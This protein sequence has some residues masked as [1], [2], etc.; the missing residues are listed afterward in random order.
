MIYILICFGSAHK[1]AY[2]DRYRVKDKARSMYPAYDGIESRYGPTKVHLQ[3]WDG[4]GPPRSSI[5]GP[6]VPSPHVRCGPHAA[7]P[8]CIHDS[9][10]VLLS[11]DSDFLQVRDRHAPAAI[12][13]A[14]AA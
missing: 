3:I 1:A 11:C 9:C 14:V 2:P 5:S 10:E 4:M 7:N 12:A 8:L 13:D 6:D